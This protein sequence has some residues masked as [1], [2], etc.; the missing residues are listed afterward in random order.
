MIF[1][2]H[3]GDYY[4]AAGIKKKYNDSRATVM[5]TLFYQLMKKR[6]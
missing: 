4:P 5:M 2:N 1:R 3:I 6:G